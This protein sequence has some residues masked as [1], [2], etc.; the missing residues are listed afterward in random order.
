MR[1]ENEANKYDYT[2]A[3]RTVRSFVSWV[4]SVSTQGRNPLKIHNSRQSMDV[5]CI[6]QSVATW[7]HGET[8][9][10]TELIQY[11]PNNT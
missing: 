7:F 11:E 6:C 8:L 5:T 9:H 2:N 1:I 4:M 10:F 3:S